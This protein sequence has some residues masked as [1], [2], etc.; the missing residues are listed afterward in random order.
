MSR[1]SH[2]HQAVRPALKARM[3]VS[4]P[5]G[6]GKTR[7][8]LIIASQLADGGPVLGIDTEK[9]SMLTYADDFEFEHLPW[10]PPFD[11]RELA[12]TLAEAGQKYAVILCDS[13]T[14]FWAGDGG[15][16]SIANGRFT[17]WKDARP[18]QETLVEAIL[19]CP[20]HVLLCVRAKME[21]VQE[22][23]ANGK[24]VVRKVGMGAV[25][26]S[27]L[28]YELNVAVDMSMD[29]T[30]TVSKS[31]TTA[32]PV[33]R[34]FKGSQVA[35]MATTYKEW[36]EAGEPPASKQDTD[37]IRARV[38]ALPER[39][40]KECQQ[41]FLAALGKVDQLRE[42]QLA[43]ADALIAGYEAQANAGETK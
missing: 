35:D 10:Q 42:A 38:T 12:E 29:H 27:T 32:L 26:D 7:S 33:G 43:D 19:T 39:L 22:Q 14:H 34:T 2:A 9:E 18:A 1:L 40:R 41:A 6:S 3:M 11:P 21:Y 23:E 13:L 25:Q 20:A 36:L 17:A 24:Q 5:S 28:E 4:G 31:R 15:T 16:L 8:S 37:A 30:A